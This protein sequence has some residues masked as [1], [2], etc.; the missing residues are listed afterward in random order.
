MRFTM[1]AP[2]LS[3]QQCQTATRFTSPRGEVNTT[4]RS[5]DASASELC[6]P[7]S[8]HD[9]EKLAL[10]PDPRVDFRFSDQ[11]HAQTKKEAKR[12]Q[13]CSQN[14][15]AIRARRAAQISVRGLPHLIRRVRSPAGV[16]PRLLGRRANASFRLRHALPGT[17]SPCPSP[18]TWSQTGRNAG[19]AFSP[20][21]PGA[22]HNPRPQAPH[23]LHDQVCLEITSLIERDEKRLFLRRRQ[24]QRRLNFSR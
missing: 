20:K 11:D 3:D 16:P 9:P 7:S 23:S 19:R 22:R 6:Q 24:S 14:D 8:A 12:R 15:R 17:R 10:G 5:R 2:C 13:A 18:A 4:S 21:P 1:V